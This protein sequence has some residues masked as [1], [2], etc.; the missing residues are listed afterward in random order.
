MTAEYHDLAVTRG[1]ASTSSTTATR[2]SAPFS[3][4]A[5][6][7]AAKVL[8]A[9]ASS[10]SSAS[11]VTEVGPGH[12]T[13]VGR[14]DDHDALRRLGRRHHGRAA[15]RGTAG[16][17][18]GRGG[19]I[20][21]QPDLTVDG[22]AGRLRRRRHRQHPRPGRQAA[23]AARLRRAAERRR[24]GRQHPR[25]RRGQAAQ[26]VPL[27]RQGHHGDDRPRRRRRRGRRAPPR[28]A[29]RDRLLGVARASTPR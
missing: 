13:L 28:A 6:D 17:P 1:A 19:R 29:R 9:R 5:H 2:C 22:V 27:P 10:S 21:V 23:P 20:D 18:Q 12:V 16:L 14:H 3:D 8:D 25:R 15:S 11:A 26:A 24:G 7:Y 4:K